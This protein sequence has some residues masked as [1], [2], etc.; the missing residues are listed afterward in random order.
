[1]TKKEYYN[2]AATAKAY[3]SKIN[4]AMEEDKQAGCLSNGIN[5]PVFYGDIMKFPTFWDAFSPLVHKILKVSRFYKR[6]YLK[7]VMKG[8]A[9]GAL[10]SYP[11]TAES[12]NPAVKALK[13]R[14]GRNQAIIRSHIKDL[15][16]SGQIDL[17][18]KQS[19]IF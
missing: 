9:A 5:P 4:L 2:K 6:T 15:L 18:V 1:M 10:D 16:S 17:N 14:F 19:E 12:Y 11:T 3:I 8:N 13:K 7:A